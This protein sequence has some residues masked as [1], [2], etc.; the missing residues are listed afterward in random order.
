MDR[1]GGG[2]HHL[3]DR[4]R[5]PH[6][7]PPVRRGSRILFSAA[8]LYLQ[9]LGL[10]HPSK[11]I[12]DAVFHAHRLDWVLGGRYFFTQP[13]PGG[14][15]FPYA[16]GL[17]V[18]AAPWSLVTNDHVT[19]LRVVVTTA[20]VVAGGLLYP[21]VARAWHHRLTGAIAV[22]LFSLVPLPSELLGNANLANVF[23]QAVALVAVIAASCWSLQRGAYGQAAALFAITALAFLSHVSTFAQLAMTLLTLS[24]WSAWQGGPE[25]RWPARWIAVVAI[26]AAL[27]AVALYYG[28]FTDVYVKALRVR[29]APAADTAPAGAG[30]AVAGRPFTARLGGALALTES[31]LG[32]PILVLAGLGAWQLWRARARDRATL[33]ILAWTA[34]YL[35]FLGV[36][37]MR[38][39][40]PFQR[41][42]A[43]FVGRVVLATYPAAVMLAGRGAGWAWEGN[44]VR[45]AVAVLLLL[46]AVVEGARRWEGWFV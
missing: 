12:I 43:E 22:A 40:G 25:L 9:L 33:A 31:A 37:V 32:W 45:R 2:D 17:Y 1:A 16:I 26:A 23:A 11:L 41:Y 28:H 27:C 44:L 13:M 38:V 14:V 39:E 35:L 7:A 19:L 42:A 15:S 20:Q 46:A 5:D 6:A 3:G 36:G 29:A 34:A 10:L 18:F 4:A 21:L 8:S 24:A 30:A